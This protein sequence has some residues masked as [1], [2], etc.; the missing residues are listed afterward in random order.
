MNLS[1]KQKQTHEH[2]EQ[3]CGCQGGEGRSGIDREF[4]TGRCKLF[5]LEW[6][7]SEVLLCIAKNSIQSLGTE[8]DER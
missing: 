8:H 1:A 7:S 6:I 3:T 2:G 5:H 4:V